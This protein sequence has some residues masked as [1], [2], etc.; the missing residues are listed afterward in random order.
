MQVRDAE[1][2]QPTCPLKLFREIADEQKFKVEYF[3]EEK[4][5]AA[6]DKFFCIISVG[7]E[8]VAFLF[9]GYGGSK[10][11]ARKS[12]AAKAVDFLRAVTLK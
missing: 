8:P 10:N 1:K 12:A 4:L 11:Q 2:S 3:D 7:L 9:H 5:M 6:E